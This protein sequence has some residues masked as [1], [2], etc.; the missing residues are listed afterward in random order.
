[1]PSQQSSSR[2]TTCVPLDRALLDLIDVAVERQ[3]KTDPSYNRS[4]LVVAALLEHLNIES[5]T[6]SKRVVTERV[7]EE[8][9]YQ[10]K[11]E[12]MQ[13]KT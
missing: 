2:T 4:E 13:S 8:K 9:A 7:V 10:Y 3:K 6:V 1:M 11:D 5:V 12:H